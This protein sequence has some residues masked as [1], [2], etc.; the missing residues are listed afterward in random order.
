MFGMVVFGGVQTAVAD[1][2]YSFTNIDVPGATGTKAYGINDSGQIVGTYSGSFPCMY[3]CSFL[4]SGGIFTQL[5]P[6]G[7]GI[8]QAYGINDSGQIVGAYADSSEI[9]H[10]FLDSAGSFTT[11][12]VP[13]AFIT[14]AYGINDSGQIV[15]QYSD[16]TGNHGFLATPT[17]V[18][19]PSSL[20]LLTICLI[21]LGA[22]AR[23]RKR[24]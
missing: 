3:T 14:Y 10:G 13:G 23:Y 17:V 24:A 22:M 8:I 6:P 16:S 18:P 19:E 15:G 9:S 7:A 1:A 5:I 12:N 4:Y 20:M 21:G 2:L 11:I